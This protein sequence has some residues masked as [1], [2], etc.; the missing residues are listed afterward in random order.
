M[1]GLG[2][3]CYSSCKVFDRSEGMGWRGL[4]GVLLENGCEDL[5]EPSTG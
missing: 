5:E 2:F 1:E 3:I 4:E